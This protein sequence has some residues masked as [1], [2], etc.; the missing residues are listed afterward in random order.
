M[1]DFD[2][3]KEIWQTISRNKS[4]SILTGFGDLLGCLYVYCDDGYRKR[5]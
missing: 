4:R 1:F 2:N 3:Y 5:L